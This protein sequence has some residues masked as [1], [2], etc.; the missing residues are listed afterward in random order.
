MSFFSKLAFWK[1][2]DGFENMGLGDKGMGADL[3]APDFGLGPAPYVD[4]GLE[5]SYG[6]PTQPQQQPSFQRPQ[7]SQPQFQQ[8][9]PQQSFTAEKDMEIIS[10][11]LDALR[12]ILDSI[13]Q[14]LANLETIAKGEEDQS[15][16]KYYRY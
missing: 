4:T 3:A 5:G 11:K 14:R 8:T 6:L 7:P 1:K 10:S 13:N 16:K 15:R 12:A 2:D 9:S